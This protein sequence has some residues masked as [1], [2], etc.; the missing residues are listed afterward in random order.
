MVR[1]N[2]TLDSVALRDMVDDQY[3]DGLFNRSIHAGEDWSKTP[4]YIKQKLN[5]IST[6]TN[7]DL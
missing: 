1:F 6:T 7:K 2:D 5:N 3:N 4:N